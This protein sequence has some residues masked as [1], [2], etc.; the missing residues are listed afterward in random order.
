MAVLKFAYAASDAALT[1]RIMNDLRGD[2]TIT[3]GPSA[4]GYQLLVLVLSGRGLADEAVTEAMYDA[5]DGSIHIIPVLAE[6][7]AVPRLIN[8]L[9]PADFSDGA[10][11]I[12]DLRSAISYLTGPNAP[13]AVRVL[14]PRTKKKNRNIGL[15]VFLVAFI[16]FT[17]G[18]IAVGVYGL[19]APAEE[20]NA[21]DT[22]VAQTRDAIIGPTLNA[23]GQYLPR[24]TDDAAV[25]ESTL[26]RMPTVHRPFIE[27]TVTAEAIR[28][29]PTAP[30]VLPMVTSAAGS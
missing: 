9:T 28:S 13:L 12:T 6:K 19:Q 18:V 10:Y 15:I 27:A 16:M 25:F 21:V 11:P 30:D 20:Y 7:V 4:E 8:H 22:E 5:L 2:H 14:T 26:Q 17:I 29:Q 3:E 24:S 23:L 1:N